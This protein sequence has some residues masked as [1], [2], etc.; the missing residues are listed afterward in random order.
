[1]ERITYKI[2]SADKKS[3]KA[4]AMRLFR[5]MVLADRVIDDAEL[6]YLDAYS[7]S[8]NAKGFPISYND[9]LLFRFNIEEQDKVNA[10][11]ISLSKAFMVFKRLREKE[12][13]YFGSEGNLI[14]YYSDPEVSDKN[15]IYLT[16][17]FVKAFDALSKCDG[18]C[19]V[20]E[21]KLCVIL[22]YILRKDDS[23]AFSMRINNMR[24][25]KHELI[26]FVNQNSSNYIAPDSE[27]IRLSQKLDL[28][29]LKLV[30][31]IHIQKELEKKA[32]YLTSL[33]SFVYPSIFLSD[34]KGQDELT[35]FKEDRMSLVRRTIASV[36]ERDFINRV[37]KDQKLPAEGNPFILFKVGRSVVKDEKKKG[38]LSPVDDFVC[39]PLTNGLKDFCE[40]FA[41]DILVI[42]KNISGTYVFSA[43]SALVIKGFVRTFLDFVV[44]SASSEI[45]NI[46]I[47]TQKRNM[48]FGDL[49]PDVTFPARSLA[50]YLFIACIS[51]MNKKGVQRYEKWTTTLYKNY[52]NLF[53]NLTYLFT[54]LDEGLI[55]DRKHIS[56]NFIAPLRN[57]TLLNDVNL[58]APL[59]L[60]DKNNQNISYVTI[61]SNILEKLFVR[62]P[63]VIKGKAESKTLKI[64]DF[65]NDFLKPRMDLDS[66]DFASN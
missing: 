46:I 14:Q 58:I 63:T 37:F 20:T 45:D 3:F 47:D 26:Y 13:D 17:N 2:S 53:K 23:F 27:L 40:E 61:D 22:N 7:S 18:N 65:L 9:S 52:E 49:I 55:M 42:A 51:L 30:N 25:S 43:D 33:F 28:Y 4:A 16:P 11:H 60:D 31:I 64:H 34:L 10:E 62:F 1:M 21:A 32:P 38:K 54:N 6:L 8:Y 36:Q 35:K 15:K 59:V 12:I 56:S 19:D 24:F 29:G 48:S 44:R 41:D 39:I 66:S 50:T 57:N 5:E